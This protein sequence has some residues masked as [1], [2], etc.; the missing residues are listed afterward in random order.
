AP[1]AKLTGHLKKPVDEREGGELSVDLINGG[2]QMTNPVAAG[3]LPATIENE[4]VLEELLSRPPQWLS[5]KLNALEGDFIVL[6][7][8]GKVGPTIARMAK[9][10]CPYKRVLGVAR[11]S[12]KEL[13][14]RIESW[15]IE[16]IACDLLDRA[17]V[18]ALPEVAN[19]IYM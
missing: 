6:G 10:A 13:R 19:V 15:G 18:E 3:Q 4:E 8:G 7:I 17:A 11:F 16:T 14:A 12:D 5:D 1:S 9:R 2:P